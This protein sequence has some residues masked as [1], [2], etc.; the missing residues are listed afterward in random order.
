MAGIFTL[1][2]GTLVWQ[3]F[4]G[5]SREHVKNLARK[6]TEAL[7]VCGK[8]LEKVTF[9]SS[10]GCFGRRRCKGGSVFGRRA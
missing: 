1:R 9:L 5:N 3:R 10:S 7:V 2:V 4:S 8:L 6:E